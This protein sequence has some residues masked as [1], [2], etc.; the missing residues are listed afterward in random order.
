[1]SSNVR[2]I[3]SESIHLLQVSTKSFF[4]GLSQVAW[5][6]LYIMDFSSWCKIYWGN[7][8]FL[9]IISNLIGWI[10]NS[11]YLWTLLEF[12][13]QFKKFDRSISSV[14][15]RLLIFCSDR[16]TH[17]SQ[18]SR[19]EDRK[20]LILIWGSLQS[21]IFQR[22][23]IVIFAWFHWFSPV[24]KYSFC[25]HLPVCVSVV[26]TTFQPPT[27]NFWQSVSFCVSFCVFPTC[28]FTHLV[29]PNWSLF[30]LVLEFINWFIMIVWKSHVEMV[31]KSSTMPK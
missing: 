28:N 16:F 23:K 4:K 12:E 25:I 21:N 6:T 24:P 20:D 3:P 1:M 29:V 10:P 2:F 9:F 14:C 22:T 27:D 7:K 8:T 13:S 30:M 26:I 5:K 17:A 11:N 31:H 19:V 18:F 15:S